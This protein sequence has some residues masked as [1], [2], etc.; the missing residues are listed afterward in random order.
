[1]S[2][3]TRRRRGPRQAQRSAEAALGRLSVGARRWWGQEVLA[4]LPGVLALDVPA[5]GV[6]SVSR[7]HD[8][9]WTS[10]HMVC[11]TYSQRNKSASGVRALCHRPVSSPPGG[12]CP[13]RSQS[14]CHSHLL[15]GLSKPTAAGWERR[16]TRWASSA[17]GRCARTGGALRATCSLAPME[18]G[19]RCTPGDRRLALS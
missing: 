5:S 17:C 12:L 18:F 3:T 2:W 14:C 1:M 6:H 15:S 13:A 11:H 10:A 16:S 19:P 4:C 9:R 8:V 7:Q